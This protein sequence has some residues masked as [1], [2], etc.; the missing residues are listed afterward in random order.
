MTTTDQIHW[1]AIENLITDP[2][3]QV[4]AGL[5]AATVDRYAEV[6]RPW[7]DD[8]EA[9]ATDL[10][11][12]P[13]LVEVYQG[14]TYL[15]DGWHRLAA[16]QRCDC[17]NVAVN[18]HPPQGSWGLMVRTAARA[19]ALHGLPLTTA[20][21][22]RAVTAWVRTEIDYEAAG[23][24]TIKYSAR[25]LGRMLG[26]SH[27]LVAEIRREMA[28]APASAPDTPAPQIPPCPESITKPVDILRWHILQILLDYDYGDPS[29]PGLTADEIT[30]PTIR[31]ISGRTMSTMV[32]AGLVDK[33]PDTP[34]RYLIMPPGVEW[35]KAR[36][37]DLEADG[38]EE[39]SEDNE[40]DETPYQP[41]PAEMEA[42]KAGAAA[43]SA[44]KPV[45]DNPHRLG[46]P[47][48]MSWAKGWRSTSP[49]FVTPNGTD[50][51]ITH[52][53]QPTAEKPPADIDAEDRE[54]AQQH[55]SAAQ[56]DDTQRALDLLRRWNAAPPLLT[57][58]QAC[59]I[60]LATGI[61]IET[62]AYDPKG[63]KQAL[64]DEAREAVEQVLGGDYMCRS[65]TLAQ[66]ESLLPTHK[67]L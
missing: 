30:S 44:G 35:L 2:R 24:Q 43:G 39:D 3:L 19:N 27:T 42:E 14:Q 33:T 45:S 47:L 36:Q 50:P 26:V 58:E 4:R 6:L 67:E 51:Q 60:V 49:D 34:T 31:K 64:I 38:D 61:D 5:D 21:K 46:T 37:R 40:D 32:T 12:P 11:L 7:A 13:L 28:P 53:I 10:P 1:I 22:R 25:E 66:I 23:E 20:D 8:A 16:Y 17:R 57:I 9:S 54:A 56:R 29:G 52:P 48:A 41:S 59:A 63:A 15:L 55:A 65:I 18:Y 62:R